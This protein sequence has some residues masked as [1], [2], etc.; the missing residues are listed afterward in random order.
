[1]QFGDP[2]ETSVAYLIL[3]H[4]Y[5]GDVIEWPIADDHQLKR[6]FDAVEQQGFIA[7]WDRTWPRHDRY[8]LTDR[9]I[10]TIESVYKPTGA[11]QV[12][13]DLCARGL[14]PPE[15]R[16]HLQ[17]QGLDPALWPLLHDPSTHWETFMSEGGRYVD[18][19]WEDQKPIRR[20]AAVAAPVVTTTTTTR[21]YYDDWDDDY[22]SYYRRHG[23][24]PYGH[25]EYY[26]RY[27]RYP[28]DYDDDDYYYRHG[29]YRNQ[30][31]TV[32]PYNV[33]LDR[34]AQST[35]VA[36]PQQSDYDVS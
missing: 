14:S 21:R 7:R 2:Q 16:A 10:A 36:P 12:W 34:E 19:V 3:R 25:D 8:R 35:N 20:R 33:D 24:Y 31:P 11:D 26:R 5:D 4:L 28:W 30:S 27:N 22:Y 32:V 1:M 23:R 15:R 6:I 29:H 9:G 13:N 17:Q 18:Y